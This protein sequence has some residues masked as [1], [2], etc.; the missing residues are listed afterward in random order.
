MLIFVLKS[1]VKFVLKN[2]FLVKCLTNQKKG[3]ILQ[4][5]LETGQS[6]SLIPKEKMK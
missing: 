2:I 6:E 5:F 1:Q 4:L 3:I